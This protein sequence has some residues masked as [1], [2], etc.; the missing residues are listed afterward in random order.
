[1]FVIF[2]R[3]IRLSSPKLNYLI[4]WGAIH[5]YLSAIGL[6]IPTTDPDTIVALCFVSG[7]V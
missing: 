6:V 2:N 7:T 5:L 4:V 1:M 3:I